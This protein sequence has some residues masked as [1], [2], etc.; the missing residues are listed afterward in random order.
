[1]VT[2]MLSDTPVTGMFVVCYLIRYIVGTY[3]LVYLVNVLVYNTVLVDPHLSKPLWPQGLISE[4]IQFS[5]K[6]AG[7]VL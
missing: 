4:A 2:Y 1:M 5:F 3:D 7:N 6:V